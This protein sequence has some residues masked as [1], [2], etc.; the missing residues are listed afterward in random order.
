MADR[1]LITQSLLSSW[2]YLYNCY[3]DYADEAMAD[4][5]RTLRRIPSEQNEAMKA[6][7][8]FEALV[9]AIADGASYDQNAKTISGAE[10]VAQIV[11][12]GQYQVALSKEIEV[13]GMTFL[14]YGVLDVLKAGIIYDIKFK[15]KSFG[16]LDL[17]GAY[18]DSPQHPAYFA[19]VP[20]AREFN[21]LVSDG[22]DL[23]IET[24][25]PDMVEPIENT[26]VE[27][28]DFLDTMGFMPDYKE[29][30]LA[31]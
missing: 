23:Y 14:L 5:M 16:S 31:K 17:A 3:E 29:Y 30:W 7:S 15:T 28:M 19:L 2:L 20:E 27:F 8:D 13:N 1:Y 26:I 4:F 10:Q 24:Y 25:T 11:K 9:Y 18:L 22:K 6:G 12:G 21:Y